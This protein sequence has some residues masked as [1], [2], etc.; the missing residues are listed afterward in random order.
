MKKKEKMK[1]AIKDKINEKK[2]KIEIQGDIDD[3]C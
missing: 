3:A 2:E 1:A